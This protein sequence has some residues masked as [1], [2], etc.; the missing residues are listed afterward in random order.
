MYIWLP[1]ATNHLPWLKIAVL[2]LSIARCS[3][4]TQKGVHH[5]ALLAWSNWSCLINMTFPE[6]PKNHCLAFKLFEIPTRP[7]CTLHILVRCS[8]AWSELIAISLFVT[9]LLFSNSFHVAGCLVFNSCLSAIYLKAV[10]IYSIKRRVC[11]MLVYGG[12]QYQNFWD[13][14]I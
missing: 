14:S 2:I 10:C 7:E 11:L 13:A 5:G 4:W 6:K 9:N 3:C 8:Q 12:E 1:S